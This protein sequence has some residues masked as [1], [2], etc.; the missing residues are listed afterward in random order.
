MPFD[1]PYWTLAEAI[2]WIATRDKGR[3]DTLDMISRNS[4]MR[5][6]T[7][8]KAGAV[9]LLAKEEDKAQAKLF[10]ALGAAKIS[11]SGVVP[12]E[13]ARN[14]IPSAAWANIR[15]SES[16][17][18]NRAF[19]GHKVRV[20]NEATI[21]ARLVVGDEVL[22]E[23]KDVRVSRA[24]VLG[25]WPQDKRTAGSSPTEADLQEKERLSRAE[26]Q[27]AG[28][29]SI[30]QGWAHEQNVAGVIIT[31]GAAIG[32]MRQR[33]GDRAI[34]LSDRMIIG[35]TR[36]LTPSWTAQRGQRKG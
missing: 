20:V 10:D 14:E 13:S 1:S 4:L 32:A 35:W 2:V 11:S 12:A 28:W 17:R 24:T 3:V 7:P 21:D 26:Q 18:F 36:E 33:I 19:A 27:Q 25:E 9:I 23:W 5:L 22:R 31:Q 8:N 30:F 15:L 16:Q 34:G 6:Y 29:Q